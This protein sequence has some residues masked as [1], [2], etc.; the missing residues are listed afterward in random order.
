MSD[1]EFIDPAT[2]RRKL[3]KHEAQLEVKRTL[4]H[5]MSDE[6]ATAKLSCTLL[7]RW[8]AELVKMEED[9]EEKCCQLCEAESNPS[10]VK[11][12]SASA[13]NFQTLMMAAQEI[14]ERLLSKKKIQSTTQALNVAVDGLRDAYGEDPTKDHAA[15]LLIVKD[16]YQQLEDEILSSSIG[17]EEG[18]I[19]DGKAAL[20][21]AFGV[22]ARAVKPIEV[23]HKPPA[24]V[25]LAK[26]SFKVDPVTVPSFSGRTEDWLPFWR[27]F[28]KAI[29]DK[30]D[31]DDDIRFTYLLR[32]MK[33][34]VMR[35]SYSERIEDDG[36]YTDII[37]ELQAEFDRPRWMHRRYCDS[38]TT[39]TT[40][41]H[42]RQGMKDLVNKVTTIYKGF[43]RLKGD[44]AKQ[45]LTSVTEAVMDKELRVLWNQRTDKV[46]EIPSI[47]D[48]LTFIKDQADQMDQVETTGEGN[49]LPRQ[50]QER[51]K[52]KFNK[53][54]QR[55]STNVT[56]SS[57]GPAPSQPAPTPTQPNVAQTPRTAPRYSCPLCPDQHYPYQCSSFNQYSLAQRKKHVQEHNLCTICL[58]PWHTASN[59]TSTY[60]CRFSKG[61][62]NS[63][64]HQTTTTSTSA[65]SST[66][67]ATQGATHSTTAA[68]PTQEKDHLLMTSQVILTGPTGTSMVARALLDSA[69]TLS[70]LSTKAQK[71]LS[72][73]KSGH[74]TFITGVGAAACSATP[75]PM[76]QVNLSSS[77]QEEWSK[78]VTV[79][80]MDQVTDDLPLQG[81]S[82]ARRLPHLQNLH[83]ADK[84]FHMPG[85]IDL[86][87]GQDVFGELLLKENRRGPSGTPSAW[88][89]VFGW[90]VM[91]PYT[92][93][94]SATK[95]SASTNIAASKAAVD[96][97]ESRALTTEEILAQMLV[98]EEPQEKD[99]VLTQ[100]EQMVEDHFETTHT[101]D[102]EEKRYTVRLPMKNSTLQLGDSR[103]QALNR[104]KVNERSLL[105]RGCYSQY[106]EVI[107]KYLDAGH[108][109]LLTPEEVAQPALAYYMPV[110]AVFKQSSS[111]TKLRAVFDAS[112]K[113]TNQT[114]LNEL[115]AVGPTLQPTLDQ[116]L[117][118][119][120]TYSVA[121]SGDISQM[122]R[123]VLLHP[124][125]RPLH[126][127]MW[128]PGDDQP[129]QDYHM[130]RVTFGVAA[131]P[132]LAVK[133]LL[134][135][136]T[137][138]LP[139]AKL[140]LEN[141]FYVDD[142]L[143]GADSP[144]AALSLYH[145]LRTV[146]SQ[147]GFQ[148]KKWR[149]SSEDVLSSIP[150]ELQES[151]PQQE[152]IDLH[153]ASYPRA[154]GIAWD[155]REDTMATHV[156]LP[157]TYVT[158]KRGV[159]SD[160]AKTFDVLG[161]LSPAILLWE[162]GLLIMFFTTEIPHTGAD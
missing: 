57:S 13:A 107:Q 74:K 22:Q 61:N 50:N 21:E 66:T 155:S 110:H 39:L 41:A 90:T 147:A 70:I 88:L 102:K 82:A 87:L 34:P 91:G 68:A 117:L 100:E 38:M 153:A 138:S 33:D 152:L 139:E 10:T 123:E 124:K 37:A 78:D 85:T 24:P 159:I 67:P 95:R 53:H 44:H 8:Q 14:C 1:A 162:L 27:V 48:L 119:F 47:E 141:S 71:T 56:T 60:K 43:I 111:T 146:L 86:L 143:G 15:S 150:E 98:I 154:L 40:N 97:D 118:R 17:D 19:M 137:G 113:T 136:A 64:L 144:E 101:Y 23:D 103:G 16:R 9:H 114:S 84:N 80:V 31:L 35:N 54:R 128:R 94:N 26:G 156:S 42:T 51:N 132:Y 158:T 104:A 11:K 32:A 130:T 89:T 120:R 112:A 116:T 134:Q 46:K 62:H 73:K 45:I 12:D 28:K 151:L 140:H 121:L 135:A 122:Y 2:L 161:W 52:G 93:D 115:M 65:G 81:A 59:C 36:A 25:V 105:R 145:D 3:A 49:R 30:V 83:L 106:Q 149:S 126:R 6:T 148:L 127:F 69:S 157:T 63:L 92:P 109:T 29:H 20:K 108:A 99:R 133:T 72:L 75:C 160:V 4:L 125:D 129:W 18:L 79:A 131:S 5:K 7:T 58:K 76:V 96:T 142:F 55:G 77:F